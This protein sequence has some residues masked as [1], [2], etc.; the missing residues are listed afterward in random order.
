MNGPRFSYL[1][2]LVENMSDEDPNSIEIVSSKLILLDEEISCE[3]NGK[4]R[5]TLFVIHLTNLKTNLRIREKE[6]TWISSTLYL[7]SI[8][9]Y[10]SLNIVYRL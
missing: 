4:T 8:H 2:A 6:E 5:G 3:E 7:E 9:L 10:D 1:V